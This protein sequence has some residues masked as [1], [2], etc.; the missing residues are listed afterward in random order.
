MDPLE[1]VTRAP[2]PF[3]ARC[4]VPRDLDAVTCVGPESPFRETRT[5][6]AAIERIWTAVRG[7]YRTGV[8]P[9]IQVCIRRH[10]QIVL[11]RAIGHASG[12]A[13]GDPPEGPR[14]PVSIETPFCLFSAS[15]A[16][17][18]MV[19]HKLDEQCVLHLEDRV[20]D[21]IPEFGAHGKHRITIRHLL[22]HRA[23]IPNLP[24]ESVDLELLSRP[25]RMIEILCEAR[26]QTRPGRFLSYHA[27]T[28]GFI[29][30][31]VVRRATGRSI[32]D[33]LAKEILD[34][35][36]LPGFSYG[37]PPE[38]LGRVAVN[39]W[40]G[41]P[42]PP[43]VGWALRRV[44]GVGVREIV[45]LSNDP[46]FLTGVIPSANVICNAVD[47]SAFYQCLLDE[48]SYDGVRV[49]DPRTVHHATGENSY[50]ELDFTLGLPLRY[51]LGFML[52]GKHFSLFGR[53]CPQ[54]FGHVG[55]TNVFTW[56]DPSRDLAVAILTSGKPV[57]STH[58]LRLV[59]LVL[60]INRSFP[61]LR[62]DWTRPGPAERR[63][64][65]RG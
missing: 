28:G 17:T 48:G 4:R 46:R 30:A 61:R 34:P 9:A 13:P 22:G 15:K 40:T 63:D 43:P 36:G 19:V 60:E 58:V 7:L 57:A 5:S 42:P 35:L 31:E 16:V 38:Q 49:F 56:A 6:R 24:P 47:A 10:G 12:N 45:R 8:H 50:W 20:V 2:L 62:P 3:L 39:A 11:N 32:R 53:D 14:V 25:E 54:A 33:V 26:P 59:Q 27:V 18:G 65:P 37:V 41:P 64:S 52:G 29:L 55:Y 23:G 44:L 1:I 51:G 21:F